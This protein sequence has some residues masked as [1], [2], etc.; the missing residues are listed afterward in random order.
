M[1]KQ[2]LFLSF[3][4]SGI[5]NVSAQVR[6]LS[7]LGVPQAGGAADASSRICTISQDA[8]F[9]AFA[10]NASNLVAND[11]NAATDVFLR[12]NS[13]GAIQRISSPT[14]TGQ[15]NGASGAGVD[16]ETTIAINSAG[17][18]IAYVS[19]A[20]N[21][22][23][24][25]T[26]NLPDIFLYEV[27][28]NRTTSLSR[29]QSNGPSDGA[30]S[31]PFI[32]RDGAYVVFESA[33]TDLDNDSNNFKDV[34][35]RDVQ[36]QFTVR[37]SQAP[38]G[39]TN[40]D[41]SYPSVSNGGQFVVFL[42]NAT[43]LLTVGTDTNESAD[44]FIVDRF[45]DTVKRASINTAGI[46]A[47]G[48]SY[49]PTMTPDGRYIAFASDSSNLIASDQNGKRD[50]F[51]RDTLQATTE[52]VS[53]SSTG[54]QGN[55]DSGLDRV[56]ISDDG[57]FV[58]FSSAATNLASGDDNTVVDIFVHDRLLK[59]TG[60]VSRTTLL[61]NS[62]SGSFMPALS[63]DGSFICYQSSATNLSSNTS[64]SS[65]IFGA[66]VGSLPA[67]LSR[68]FVLDDTP[69]VA[70]A[71]KGPKTVTAVL[72]EFP[73]VDLAPSALVFGRIST[74]AKPK[75]RIEYTTN[76]KSLT[77]GVRDRR[78]VMS[79]K[80]QVTFKNVA[81][82][83]YQITYRAAAFRGDKRIARSSVSPAQTFTV[84]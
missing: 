27:S 50:I 70:V 1:K 63:S 21:L 22:V 11:T 59:R 82:G 77:P 3:I 8:A 48:P 43:N 30:S 16:G 17:T 6:S 18:M 69:V 66:T 49:M 7:E 39:E 74:R 13:T 56:S 2:L 31:F 25:D 54:V 73:A 32:S 80:N 5:F 58:A 35:M 33:A 46:E 45:N 75:T 10:S 78:R 20:S 9:V 19:S 42:S 36:Q 29:D 61:Q 72:Q 84:P 23:A 26:N 57:R 34:Y 81:S 53:I 47:N 68:G 12:N 60:R 52:I 14:S 38:S 64:S 51:V 37:I 62:N 79:R 76:F 71:A 28:S 4:C 65:K 15:G 44:V 41:S 55:S 67:E 24:G 83:N 40:G